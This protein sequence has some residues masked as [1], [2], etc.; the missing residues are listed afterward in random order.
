MRYTSYLSRI[1]GPLPDRWHEMHLRHLRRYLNRF[2]TLMTVRAARFSD[3]VANSLEA[4]GL[5]DL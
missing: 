5:D 3:E 2:L 1:E 4:R